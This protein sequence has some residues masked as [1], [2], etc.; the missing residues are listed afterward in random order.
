MRKISF[1]ISLWLVFAGLGRAQ[2]TS[3]TIRGVVHLVKYTVND[4]ASGA[5]VGLY[6]VKTQ[7]LIEVRTNKLGE[8]RFQVPA[9]EYQLG[10]YLPGFDALKT[11]TFGLGQGG[12]F[13]VNFRFNNANHE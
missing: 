11:S 13:K 7:E 3:T 1:A 9:G 4:L 6:N 5:R 2:S 12:S 10:A 8:Y